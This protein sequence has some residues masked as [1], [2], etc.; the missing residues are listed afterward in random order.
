MSN[1]RTYK[2]IKQNFSKERIEEINDGAD[3][4]RKELNLLNKIRQT[5]GLT[6]EELTEFLEGKQVNKIVAD[7]NDNSPLATI[8]RLIVARGGS[9]DI[10]INFPEKEPVQFSRIESLFL[11][12]KDEN[13]EGSNYKKHDV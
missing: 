6:E 10:T 1:Y 12:G 8:I 5:A 11:L 3:K 9:I 4:I 7:E 2:E 13:Q